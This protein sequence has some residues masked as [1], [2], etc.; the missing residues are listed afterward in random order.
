MAFWQNPSF[1]SWEANWT[2]YDQV[3]RR[4]TLASAY[5]S[6]RQLTLLLVALV[7]PLHRQLTEIATD[8]ETATDT[9][10]ASKPG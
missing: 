8:A 4:Q 10:T 5:I 7:A 3:T 1:V 9:E 2:L 6:V